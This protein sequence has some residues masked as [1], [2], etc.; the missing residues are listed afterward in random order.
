MT[1]PNP[2]L[3]PAQRDQLYGSPG[4]LT[5]R[6]DALL[7]AKTAG[8]N[9][10]DVI[11]DLAAT[12]LHPRP[13][14]LAVLDV[15]CGR[16]STTGR[17]ADRLHPETLLAIDAAPALLADARTRH[18]AR[19]GLGW[20]AAD[21]HHLPLPPA[22]L[23]LA[24]AAFCLYHSPRPAAAVAE[25]ARCL[26]PGGV[27]I[28]ATKSADSYA[29]LD[30]LVVTAGLDVAAASR[31]SLYQTFNTKNLL[32]AVPAEVEVDQLIHEI[33]QFRFRDLAHVARYLATNPKYQLPAAIRGSPELIALALAAAVPDGPV[34]A[35]STVSYAVA[36]RT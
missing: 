6:T 13:A 29:D 30:A 3:D 17:L 10:A 12:A 8:R 35:H 22:R 7:T 19:H 18:G 26:R 31:P 20:V 23:D 2:F 14:N 25:V 15:G 9:A 11:A 24:V 36:R 5:R 28:F 27:L 32:D 1:A 21:F 33:H 16:G 34:H 4:R